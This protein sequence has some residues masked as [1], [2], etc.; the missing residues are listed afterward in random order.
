MLGK[1]LPP[2]LVIFLQSVNPFSI[3]YF[4]FL[5]KGLSIV[6]GLSKTKA[7]ILSI[8]MW[9]ISVGFVISVLLVTGSTRIRIKFGA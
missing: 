8:I 5:A 3:W 2:A 1:D 9:L 4:M 7:R 6:T